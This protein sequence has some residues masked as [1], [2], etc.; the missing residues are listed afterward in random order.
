[1]TNFKMKK[2]GIDIIWLKST[3]LKKSTANIIVYLIGGGV[4]LHG[5]ILQQFIFSLKLSS[6]WNRLTH[7][8]QQGKEAKEHLF[9]RNDVYGT[10]WIYRVLELFSTLLILK[11]N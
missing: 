4:D 2:R 5:D 7:V 8:V 10:T 11:F 9:K 1:M 6:Q 3:S